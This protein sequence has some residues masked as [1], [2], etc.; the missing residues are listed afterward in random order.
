MKPPFPSFTAEWHNNTYPAIDPK[1]P[2]LSAK[3]KK[4]V[5]TGGGKRLSFYLP[6][7]PLTLYP[8]AGIGLGIATAFAAAGATAIGILG[9]RETILQEAKETIQSKH[10]KVEIHIYAADI[11]DRPALDRAAKDFGT[12]DVLVS[13]AAYM[14]SVG[15]VAEVDVEDWWKAFEVSLPESYPLPN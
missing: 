12:W 2:E 1:R 8:G 11:T 14:P 6:T 7:L 15:P 10:P 3:G 4:V 9:R 13:N 5:V